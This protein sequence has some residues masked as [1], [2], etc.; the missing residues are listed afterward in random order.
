MKGIKAMGL[1]FLA[2]LIFSSGILI[3]RIQSD[4]PVI[5]VLA[6]VVGGLILKYYFHFLDKIT[7]KR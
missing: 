5:N 7:N 2:F 4:K 1:H 3:I 6:I